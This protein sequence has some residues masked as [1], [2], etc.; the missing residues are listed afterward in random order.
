MNLK[1]SLFFVGLT[2]LSFNGSFAAEGNEKGIEYYRAELYNAAILFLNNQVTTTTGSEQAEAYYYIGESYAAL[3]KNDS[4]A[5]FYQKALDADAEYPYAYIGQGKLELLVNN[6]KS[7]NDLFKKAIGF[8]KKNPAIHTT[9]A[10]AYIHAQLYDKA[11]EAL[12]QARSRDKKFSGIYVAE[13]DMLRAQS[14]IGEACAKYENA[15]LFDKNDKVAYL[16]E[17][18]VYKSINPKSALDILNRLIEVDP[19]YIPAYAEL[20]D[21]YY[22]DGYYP[23]ALEAY[24][25][26]IAIPGVPVKYRMNYASILYFQKEYDKSL[27]EIRRIMEKEPDNV[28]MHRLQAYNNY[29]LGNYETGLEGME[30]FFKL[31]PPEQ[32]ITLDYTYYGRLL[33]KNKKSDLAIEAFKQSLELDSSKAEIYKE[34]AAAYNRMN[35]YPEAI[36][37]YRSYFEKDAN[38][39]L[40][41]LFNFGQ[42][43]Y[44]GASQL[45]PAAPAEGAKKVVMSEE[46]LD[47]RKN[48][49]IQRM[50]YLQLADNIF[51]QVSERSP[52][53]FLGYLW[54]GHTQASIDSEV[55][56]GLAKPHYEKAL[57][58]MEASNADGRRNKDIVDAYRYLGY[59]YYLQDD[60]ENARQCYEKILEILPDDEPSKQVLEA[61]KG[62]KRR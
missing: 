7:A 53:S 25:K 34:I 44:V 16:K 56:L 20:G 32:I 12:D 27:V 47:K 13:G 59:Y 28:V 48:D 23:K 45:T 26:F 61:T 58:I 49:S 15:I 3:A 11:N 57:S 30:T 14:K 6:Q 40:L 29:E 62:N 19:E 17:A 4:A 36:Q 35:L 50:E 21:I 39:P 22:N 43:C 2:C 46:E 8:A 54:R 42:T 37:Y 55:T 33:E 10:E 18:R 9:V 51:E 52:D 24:S 41:D 38:A 31:I 1:R 5:I 60:M